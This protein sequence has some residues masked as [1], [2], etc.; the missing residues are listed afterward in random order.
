MT[1]TPRRYD[2]RYIFA[3]ETAA[4]ILCREFGVDNSLIVTEYAVK[5]TGPDVFTK[6]NRYAVRVGRFDSKALS[7]ILKDY[8]T[9]IHLPYPEEEDSMNKEPGVFTCYVR[10]KH[11]PDGAPWQ[12]LPIAPSSQS[13]GAKVRR[14]MRRMD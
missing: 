14:E 8:A 13:P 4:N 1:R 5:P 7:R 12:E 3:C 6:D 9:V 11:V 2:E 10:N